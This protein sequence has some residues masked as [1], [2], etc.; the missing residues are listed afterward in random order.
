[1][2]TLRTMGQ[3]TPV[4]SRRPVAY[5][6]AM[7]DDTLPAEFVERLRRIVPA[8]QW[9]S[10]WQ[11]FQQERPPVLRVNT[12]RTTPEAMVAALEEEGINATPVSGKPDALT[13]P[14]VQRAEA[15]ASIPY[16]DG[17][18][19]SQNLA[20]QMAPL[21]L[22][23]QPGEEVLDMCAAPGGKTLQLACL[24]RGKGRLAAVEKVKA[25]YFKLKANLAQQ[26]VDL[27]HTYLADGAGLWRKVPERFDR[28]LLDAPCSSEARFR[29]GQPETFAHWRRKKVTEMARKQKALLFSAIDVLKPGGVLL[30]S[31]CS[32]APEENEA[33]VD[34]ALQRFGDAIQ[35]EPIELPLPD[36]LLNC[37][38][39]LSEWEGKAFDPQL[40]QALRILPNEHMEG[41][42]LCRLRKKPQ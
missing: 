42:F 14:L 39:G 7:T 23:P 33:T 17:L 13:L 19:Y 22:D 15:L 2:T 40:A 5:N 6:A 37:Q 29:A 11:S 1:M 38:P 34:K 9:P 27:V 8:A 26:Q 25:R 32:F 35:V 24:M 10:V 4:H 21:A 12:L 36:S 30:Y 18:L 16:R 41:F 20:S 28:T 31:T 3:D